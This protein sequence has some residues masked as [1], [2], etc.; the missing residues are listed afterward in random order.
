M[1]KV[2]ILLLAVLLIGGSFSVLL[3]RLARV[4]R[5]N[6]RQREQIAVMRESVGQAREAFHR[7]LEAQIR[8]RIHYGTSVGLSFSGTPERQED[9][10]FETLVDL[11]TEIE[12]L[13][14][15]SKE[16]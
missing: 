8:S 1:K 3:V 15:V 6:A 14:A 5:E 4:E 16:R 7:V 2:S 11:D 13:E 10:D 9:I 12:M